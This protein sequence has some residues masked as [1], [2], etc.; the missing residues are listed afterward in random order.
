MT[1]IGRCSLALDGP[2]GAAEEAARS[3]GGRHEEGAI[4]LDSLAIAENL[5]RG[6]LDG[7]LATGKP[8]SPSPLGRKVVASGHA[9]KDRF[10]LPD[11]LREKFTKI[12]RSSE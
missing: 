2:D 3:L 10:D 4:G 8:A 11:D 1:V 7:H 5:F 9:A 12:D 6:E